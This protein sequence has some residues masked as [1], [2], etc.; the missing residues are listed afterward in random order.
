M[1][2]T[3]YKV[4]NKINGKIYIGAHQTENLED[5]YM[6]SGLGILKAIKEHGK[7]NFTKEY[8]FIF[9][10]RESMLAME[11]ELVTEEFA[12]DPNTYNLCEGGG[13]GKPIHKQDFDRTSASK[14]S[15]ARKQWLWDNDPEWREAFSDRRRKSS[16]GNTN[17]LGKKH[18]KESKVKMSKSHKGKHEGSKNSQF[19]TMW[20]TNGIDNKKIRKDDMIPE[21]WRKGRFVKS[22]Y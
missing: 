12:S 13:A 20:I 2:Y 17:F 21:G 6:G 22:K 9:D 11:K 8:L 3:V 18:T 1:L 10:N 14:R 4:T 7:Q 16:L 19:G 15:N 5:G